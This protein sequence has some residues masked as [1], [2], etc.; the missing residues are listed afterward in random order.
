ML[1]FAALLLFV[2]LGCNS[3]PVAPGRAAVEGTE[4]LLPTQSS[5]QSPTQSEGEGLILPDDWLA[6]APSVFATRLATW[7]A[8]PPGLQLSPSAR[9][10]LTDAL[11]L[12]GQ[13][14]PGP[15]FYLQA[16]RTPV[17]PLPAAPSSRNSSCG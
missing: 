12:S 9:T 13:R 15:Q 10:R 4:T 7:T 5:T 6:V 1:R 2:L 17:T 8:T 14:A 3:A 11:R 16:P